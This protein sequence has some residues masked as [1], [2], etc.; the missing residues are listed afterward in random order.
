M[1]HSHKIFIRINLFVVFPALSAIGCFGDTRTDRFPLIATQS[2]LSKIGVVT[3]FQSTHQVILVEE[4]E[5]VDDQR[6]TRNTGLF[7][8][9]CG[10]Y[11]MDH[12]VLARRF[13]VHAPDKAAALTGQRVA[14]WMSHLWSISEDHFGTAPT[15]LRSTTI[16]V[17]L[18][19]SGD[20]G[21]E[22]NRSN[23]YIYNLG[24]DRTPIEWTRELSH[25]YGHY[26]LPGA[27]GYTDPENW[28]NGILG[29]RMFLLWMQQAL[30]A[31]KI[32]LEDLP[33]VTPKEIA[34]YCMLQPKALIDRFAASGPDKIVLLGTDKSAMNAFTALILAIDQVYG[35]KTLTEILEYLPPITNAQ[36]ARG[37]DFLEAIQRWQTSQFAFVTNVVVGINRIYLAK[38]EY[39]VASEKASPEIKIPDAVITREGDELHLKIKVDGWKTLTAARAGQLRWRKL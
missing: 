25:E 27:S 18:T 29:E 34:E 6:D 22:Q 17:W 26:L 5:G 11:I 4:D 14:K 1:F 12:N 36:G 23:I 19:R 32:A 35:S 20:P 15:R 8:W 2:E 31:R 7:K 30:S 9:N 28:S 39:S 37:K 33:F 10:V 38:G 3:A 24:T 16:D 21:G 13:V